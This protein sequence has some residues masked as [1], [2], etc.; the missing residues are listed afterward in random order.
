MNP[1]Y[2]LNLLYLLEPFQHFDL[3]YP[4]HVVVVVVVK[5]A[6]LV[7]ESWE[8]L[9]EMFVVDSWLIAVAVAVA[10]AFSDLFH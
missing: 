1:H 2:F 6:D 7:E 5:Q 9:V 4:L 3:P 8:V 10:A